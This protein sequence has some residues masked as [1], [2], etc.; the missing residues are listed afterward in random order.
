MDK[1][2]ES[3]KPKS[4][5][6]EELEESIT[7]VVKRYCWLMNLKAPVPEEKAKEN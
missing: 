6:E 1:L 5:F 2:K 7:E 4:K 3:A